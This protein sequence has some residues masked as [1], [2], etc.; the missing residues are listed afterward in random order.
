[1]EF[2]P[3]APFWICFLCVHAVYLR[4]GKKLRKTDYLLSTKHLPNNTRVGKHH[5]F[6]HGTMI[7]HGDINTTHPKHST[8]FGYH[9]LEDFLYD[10]R[11]S[12]R[13][14]WHSPGFT[15]IALL[16]L[17]LGVG[18]NISVFSV[19]KAVIIRPLP[20]PQP[21]RLMLLQGYT[22][23]TK[24]FEDW[25]KQSRCY[26]SFAVLSP[27][28]ATLSGI[29]DPERVSIGKTSEGFFSVLGVRP[30][31]GRFFISEDFRERRP[32][33][34]A[35]DRFWRRKLGAQK[36]VIGRTIL[37]NNQG[38]TLVG[39]TPAQLGPL[40]YSEE[41]LWL[42][43]FPERPQLATALVRLKQ[44]VSVESAQTE[45]Q[46]L[47]TGFADKNGAQLGRTMIRALPYKDFILGDAKIIFFVLA[48]A[49]GFL[50]LITCANVANLL[51]IH[52]SV[53]AREIA[54][55]I[56]LGAGRGRV[57]RQLLTECLLLAMAGSTAGLL[58]GQW[59]KT[60]FLH[61]LPYHVP[62]IDT[63]VVDWEVMSFTFILTMAVSAG[64]GLIPA[65]RAIHFHPQ[66]ALK[67]GA[68][69]SMGSRKSR[70]LDSILVVVQIAASL[71]LLIGAGLLLKVFLSLRPVHTGFDPTNRV[72]Q[73]LAIP[74]NKYNSEKKVTEFT[75][76][77]MA[78]LRSLPGVRNAA[79]VSNLP[80]KEYA[81]VPEIQIDG[82][83]VAGYGLD[84]TVYN[85]FVSPSY[86]TTMGIALRKGRIFGAAKEAIVNETMTRRLWPGKDPLGQQFRMDHREN[87]SWTVVGVVQDTRVFAK[88]TKP[89]AELYVPFNGSFKGFSI[90]VHTWD[91]PQKSLPAINKVLRDAETG[92][93]MY[94]AQ[95][96]EDFLSESIAEQR[97]HAALMGSLAAIALVIAL[98]G[99]YG[100]ISYSVR[101]RTRELSIR[102]VV[103]AAPS[104]L[105][106]LVLREGLQLAILGIC[107]GTAGA[108]M[109]TRYLESMLYQVRAM[110][111]AAFTAM[112]AT[113]LVV[114][115]V[116]SLLPALR[117]AFTDPIQVLRHQ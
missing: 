47:A 59:S 40:P 106:W 87:D 105:L 9:L 21:E 1:M 113:W 101:L 98:V 31:L 83:I 39:V 64:I 82:N 37:L 115:L 14:L 12:C 24:N 19:I 71:V 7:Q 29:E 107:L 112:I 54:M 92:M 102:L 86:F 44:G 67:E 89:E 85:R 35:G 100:V 81:F 6:T 51:L 50:L 41:E 73:S 23:N 48:G 33:V 10:L 109:L 30:A 91:N 97:F 22:L 38:Y 72:I 68:G 42:P 117:A 13:R 27:E 63:A 103:G 84:L 114:A 52:T 28:N 15:L 95:E 94:Q 5:F 70:R 20:F 62:R 11:Y 2:F 108:L 57:M 78:D 116:A 79:V 25:E 18:A 49:V 66:S 75:D 26:E 34:I 46:V 53:Y 110:D 58:V 56:A 80:F 77:I 76:R 32:V 88:S 111:P 61:L 69:T 55:R 60:L 90:V 45:A 17:A 74:I 104:D 4:S 99:I 8:I 65:L 3:P 16:T 96:M 36:D 43:L 93:I